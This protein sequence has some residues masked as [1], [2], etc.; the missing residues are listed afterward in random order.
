MSLLLDNYRG[1]RSDTRPVWFMRQAGRS[2]PEYRQARGNTS[3]LDACLQPELVAEI[4]AQPVRRHKVDAGIFYSDIVVP[5]KLAGVDVEIVPGTGPVVASPIRCA[6]DIAALPELDPSALDVIVEAARQSS[7]ALGT[8]PL[9]GFAGAP[10]TVASYLVEGRPSRDFA[11]TLALLNEDPNAWHALLSWVST[12]S[13]AFLDAQIRGGAQAVQLF[14]SWAG[15][16]SV[17]QYQRYVQEHSAAVFNALGTAVPRVHFGT[18]T[19]PLL[20]AM[21]ATGADVMGIDAQTSLAQAAKRLPGMALQGNID[22]AVLTQPWEVIESH[23]R[24]VVAAGRELPGHVV[25]LG[26]GVPPAT[27][28]DVLTRIVELVHSLTDKEI[29]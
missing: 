24:A 27:D 26:H 2:L 4:T 29:R 17:E 3:M 1:M 5:V 15:N 12:I 13:A 9:I 21:A 11:H 19:G 7:Q 23:V 28:P 10:F 16:L 8:T 22:P 6:A 20:E 14:D 18:K 25:N